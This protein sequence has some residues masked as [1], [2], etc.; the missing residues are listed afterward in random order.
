M[1]SRA[2]TSARSASGSSSGSVPTTPARAG[3]GKVRSGA[4]PRGQIGGGGHRGDASPADSSSTAVARAERAPK[5]K[6]ASTMPSCCG[7][8]ALMTAARSARQLEA[9]KVPGEAPTPRRAATATDQP[10]SALKRSASS[11]AAGWRCDRHPYSA[12]GRG[13]GAG[14]GPSTSPS[15]DR[16]LRSRGSLRRRLTST[17]VRLTVARRPRSDP[18]P[19]REQLAV[20]GR[21]A[22][23]QLGGLGPLEVEV[24]GVLPGEPDATVDLDVLGRRVE[25]G[26]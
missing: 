1:G 10:T 24:G 22:E 17:L 26:L 4:A 20:V 5:P 25:V 21:V 7:P 14:V 9:E 3:L 19:L 13:T 18:E 11:G 8:R 12:A 6:P 23:E 16:R 2:R 15:A